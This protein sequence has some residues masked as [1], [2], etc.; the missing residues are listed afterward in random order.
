MEAESEFPR[1]SQRLSD[2]KRSP[3]KNTLICLNVSISLARQQLAT[4][5]ACL[6]N[7]AA[8][9]RQRLTQIVDQKTSLINTVDSLKSAADGRKFSKKHTAL[10][11]KFCTSLEMDSELQSEM[12]VYDRRQEALA[13]LERHAVD[14]ADVFMLESKG[15]D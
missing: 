5:H 9:N 13:V 12:Q 4:L 3:S 14:L 7:K 2:F 6:Q 1:I 11:E 8:K 10:H 15:G